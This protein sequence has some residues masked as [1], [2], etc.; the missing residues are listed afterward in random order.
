MAIA[1][2]PRA[3]VPTVLYIDDEEE[4]RIVFKATFR[5][6]FNVLVAADLNEAWKTLEAETVH[7]VICDQR[8]PGVAGTEALRRIR[9]RYPQVY[10]MLITAHADLQALVDALNEG[11][12]C[13]YIQKPWEVEEVQRA[14]AQA[15]AQC[16]KDMERKAYTEHLLESNR[17]L[18][19]ALRQSLLS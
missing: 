17:Q 18:E 3:H 13:H 2:H 9:E 6:E 15:W 14:V 19:F 11:G 8:M 12:V 7:V 5:K 16:Q 10:R 1:L 4:N